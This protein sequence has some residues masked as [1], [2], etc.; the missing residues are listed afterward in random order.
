MLTSIF[1][2]GGKEKA[3]RR[4]WEALM[5]SSGC[6]VS[7]CWARAGDTGTPHPMDSAAGREAQ[8]PRR[9]QGHSAK[10]D[11]I[12]QARPGQ[13]LL[14]QCLTSLCWSALGCTDHGV[15]PSS[16]RLRAL[17]LSDPSVQMCLS[18]KHPLSREELCF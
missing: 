11:A 18:N 12:H 1:Y 17:S 4:P 2:P 7:V 10:Q 5:G 3:C 6:A 8:S 16:G 15:P 13:E 9:P 14:L